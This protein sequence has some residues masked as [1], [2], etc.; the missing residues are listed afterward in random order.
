MGRHDIPPK[1][2]VENLPAPRRRVFRGFVITTLVVLAVLYVAAYFAVRTEGFRSYAQDYIEKRLGS[3]VRIAR[4]HATL[5]LGFVL[6]D[7]TTLAADGTTGGVLR[8]R[9][10]VG[11]WS[12]AGLVL[13]ERPLWRS[14]RLRDADLRLVPGPDGEWEPA[15]AARLA[16][17]LGRQ[18][19]IE[20]PEARRPG[21]PDEMEPPAEPRVK[22]DAG[23]F[24]EETEL[25][26]E[27]GSVSW[28]NGDGVEDLSATGI[29]L[30]VT[31]VDLPH[32]RMTHFYLSA[33]QL[34]LPAGPVRR[35][36]VFEALQTSSQCIVLTLMEEAGL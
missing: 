23:N 5:G 29:D 3:P 2:H 32:R 15:A 19:G 14:I 18:L 4:S 27:N 9:R 21:S 1:I 20:I 30:W 26:L 31:P 28:L 12:P 33:G 36:V 22:A 10:M 25:V 7:V 11:N 6:E 35:D 24:W 17:W 16:G 13:R 8:V 34:R